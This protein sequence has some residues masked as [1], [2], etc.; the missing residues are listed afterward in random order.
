MSTGVSRP[1]ALGESLRAAALIAKNRLLGGLSV[2][3]PWQARFRYH[4][5]VTWWRD[6]AWAGP[7]RRFL[8]GDAVF[9][10]GENR[11]LDRRFFAIQT[12]RS[13]AELRGSTAECG[14]RRG[15]GSAMICQ[16]LREP[17]RRR[18]RT[19]RSIRSKDCRS[20]KK[21]TG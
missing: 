6:R 12:A 13:V 17:M 16:A 15:T 2:L 21:P 8:A 19:S 9:G 14:V 7:Y 11:I 5:Q 4:E 18:A 1:L 20:R 3:W 10:K